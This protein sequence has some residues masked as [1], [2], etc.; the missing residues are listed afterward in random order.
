[1]E[2]VLNIEKLKCSKCKYS[3]YPRTRKPPVKCPNCQ[4]RNWQ[5][6]IKKKNDKRFRSCQKS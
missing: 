3:W 2:N 5:K 1:M 4:C 6:Y